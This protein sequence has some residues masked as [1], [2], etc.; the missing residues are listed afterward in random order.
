[1]DF[2]PDRT[3][4]R[5]V[6]ADDL[7]D[8]TVHF[9]GLAV[10]NHA[11]EKLGDVD[12][13]ILDVAYGRPYYVVVDSG[14]WFKSKLYLIPIGHARLSTDNDALLADLTRERINRFPGF[15][16]DEFEKL[17]D[18]ELDRMDDQLAAACCPTELRNQSASSRAERWSHHRYPDWWESNYYRPDRAGA[19]AV[20]AGAELSQPGTER[21]VVW[22]GT[23]ELDTHRDAVVAREGGE[24]SPH[25]G[26]RAQPGDVIGIETGG[27][28]THVGDTSEDE[29]RVRRAGEKAAGK[30]EKK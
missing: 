14:G 5:Y 4:L 28:Q 23:P 27:E 17:S 21:N 6:D 11:G 1:M 9:D 2:T 15:D 13:F 18:A 24:T 12:G 19:R 7:D 20:T 16:R 10:R 8:S 30:A 25:P 3:R 26:G 22:G 29:D